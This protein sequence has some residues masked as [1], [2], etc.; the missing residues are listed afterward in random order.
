VDRESGDGNG[1]SNHNDDESHGD[2]ESRVD[3]TVLALELDERHP[4]FLHDAKDYLLDIQ[5]D[6]WWGTLLSR[7]FEF[8][9]LTPKVGF[10][11]VF[12]AQAY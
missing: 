5:G 6:D 8:E 11:F 2:E 3:D 4:G 10:L 12:H 1:E 9:P 7:Y